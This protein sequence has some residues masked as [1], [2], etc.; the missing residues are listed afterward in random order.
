[1]L[2]RN[3]LL[4]LCWLLFAAACGSSTQATRDIGGQVTGLQSGSLI[5]GTT[6]GQSV[7]VTQNGNFVLPHALVQGASYSIFVLTAP[8]GQSCLV[9]HGTGLVG[10]QDV[11]D[12]AV[13]CSLAFGYYTLG[14]SVTGLGPSQSTGLVLAQGQQK[15]SIATDGPFTFIAPLADLAPYAVGIAAL[16]IGQNCQLQ[17]AQGFVRAAHIDDI[18]ILCQPSPAIFVTIAVSG[19]VQDP[20]A[21][22]DVLEIDDIGALAA[23]PLMYSSQTA[24]AQ[25]LAKSYTYGAPFTLQLKPPSDMHCTWDSGAR[26]TDPSIVQGTLTGN[27]TLDVT[28]TPAQS[29]TLSVQVAGVTAGAL[30]ASNHQSND[31]ANPLA[32]DLVPTAAK[33]FA[34]AYTP[35]QA[36]RVA[37]AP[38]AGHSCAPTT[39]SPALAGLMVADTTLSILCTQSPARLAVGV[40]GVSRGSVAVNNGLS[41]DANNPLVFLAG[42]ANAARYFAYP[43][44]A[45]QT[46]NLTLK[47]DELACYFEANGATSLSQTLMGDSFVA[48]R[49]AETIP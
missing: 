18:R 12:V 38:P 13:S 35:G 11:T 30:L 44:T 9:E 1:M 6:D 47:A 39:Q 19:L 41:Q 8:V 20:N 33:S 17:N 4:C 7:T 31:V 21:A 22:T 15:L 49:C 45:G 28:C 46:A 37:I 16:P 29:L 42:D 25:R 26:P 36:Y 27:T 40:S 34:Y 10:S 2:L 14:G 24:Q 23:A 5:L 48:V 32:F 43:Y 3:T